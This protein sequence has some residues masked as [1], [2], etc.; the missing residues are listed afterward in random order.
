MGHARLGKSLPNTRPW[1]RVVG[2]IAGGASA[3]KVAQATAEA[4]VAGLDE[5]QRDPGMARILYLLA[6]T[7]LATRAVDFRAEL[8]KLGIRVPPSPSIYDLTAG[9]SESFYQWHSSTRVPR[10]DFGEM[11]ELAATEAMIRCT[12]D[13]SQHLIATGDELQSTFRSFSTAKGFSI[14]AHEFFAR[15]AQRFLHFH[16]DRELSHHIGGNGRFHDREARNVF[17]SDLQTHCQQAAIIVEKYAAD[18]FSK[19]KFEDGISEDRAKSF[20]Q[21]CVKKLRDELLIRG[22]QN[23]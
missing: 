2:H 8:E 22:L 16:L 18:W 14:L 15:F 6:H 20:A 5:A 19:A 10:T 17:V 11:A 4:A 12:K 23:V 1:Q 21:T 7:A 13:R 3:A 9:F